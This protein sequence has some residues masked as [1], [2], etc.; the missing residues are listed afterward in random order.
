M[1]TGERI[2][3]QRIPN[4]MRIEAYRGLIRVESPKLGTTWKCEI[5]LSEKGLDCVE[6]MCI[7]HMVTGLSIEEDKDISMIDAYVR[8]HEGSIW[9]SKGA[10]RKCGE[11]E[12][13]GLIGHEIGH[14]PGPK[15][16]AGIWGATGS[17]HAQNGN[18]FQR[19]AGYFMKITENRIKRKKEF[20][21]DRFAAESGVGE[22]LIEALRK[23][24]REIPLQR[25]AWLVLTASFRDHPMIH[26]R[27]KHIRSHMEERTESA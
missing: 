6:K 2:T 13:L 10:L 18:I 5:P 16:R 1:A 26:N 24:W 3:N 17:R 15:M 7:R 8:I 27:V 19:I 20:E 23:I 4:I 12:L 22:G 14:M 11:D 21:A 9:L 25:R